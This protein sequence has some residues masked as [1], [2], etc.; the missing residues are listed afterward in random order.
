MTRTTARLVAALSTV[1]LV[2]IAAPASAHVGVSSPDAAKEGF[3]KAVFRVPNESDTAATTK[4]VVTLP[5]DTPFA[6]LTAQSKPGWKATITKAKLPKPT[7]VGDYDLTEAV[8]TVTWTA[9]D[10]GIPVGQFDEFAISG[11]PFPDAASI[12]FDAQQTYSDGEVVDWNQKQAKGE[13]EP[14]HPAPVLT[15]A[16]PTG[17]HHGGASTDTSKAAYSSELS[18]TKDD[19][20]D[21]LGTWLGGGALVVALAA[22]VVALRQTRRRA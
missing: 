5:T 14:E 1:A 11:G 6:F 12:S 15:L 7:T 10:G 21:R 13:D 17:D 18:I 19:D 3:G 20:G 2:A 22:L 16:E 4:I 8:S 9:E